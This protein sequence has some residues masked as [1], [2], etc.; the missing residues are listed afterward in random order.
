MRLPTL[1]WLR[2]AR[3]V[4]PILAAAIFFWT[5]FERVAIDAKTLGDASFRATR[6]V[7]K[8]WL[9]RALPLDYLSVLVV[10]TP[11]LGGRLSS[12]EDRAL[13]AFHGRDDGTLARL[14]AEDGSSWLPALLRSELLIERGE[15][16]RALEV[17]REW[18]RQSAYER[19]ALRLDLP[20]DDQRALIHFWHRFAF[21]QHQTNSRDQKLFWQ[22]LKNPI[23]R[24]RMLS[25][26]GQTELALGTPTWDRHPLPAPFCSSTKL[27]SFDLYNN[28]LVAYLEAPGFS[29]TA[30]RRQAELA[31]PYDDRPEVNPVLAALRAAETTEVESNEGFV[32]ALSNAE[33]LLRDLR[34]NRRGLPDHGQLATNLAL[35]IAEAE[36]FLPA[37]RQD[38]LGLVAELT[39]K[40][41]AR[42][43]SLPEIQPMVERLEA[44][45]LIE[46]ASAAAPSSSRAELGPIINAVALRRD[47]AALETWL[48]GKTEPEL[49]EEGARWQEALRTD[50]AA[51]LAQNALAQESSSAARGVAARQARALLRGAQ[52]PA[53][54]IA[55]EAGLPF[56]A[57]WRSAFASTGG[58]AFLA[59]LLAGALFVL[60][61]VL[62]RELAFRHYLLTS[63][64][65][66]EA[67]GFER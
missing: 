50:L 49:G 46:T 29:E 45:L 55:L 61:F 5:G 24:V 31:R 56:S 14:G 58:R 7:E 25:R 35:L 30:R 51:A 63:F 44:L 4:V 59:L 53:E 6:H 42:A 64:Y 62:E 19:M 32:W 20:I 65:R 11:C 60:L 10:E 33:R 39:E 3:F 47:P 12:L 34:I 21:L 48:Q 15:A 43:S 38:L 27:S 28:L 40:A 9:D 17:L 26:G 23:G 66:R 22:S 18:S 1:P 8:A 36:R 2:A 52:T 57:R 16:A 37:Q 54:L 41:A 67:E 13:T